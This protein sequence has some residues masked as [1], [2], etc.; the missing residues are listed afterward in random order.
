M[1][2]NHGLMFGSCV[3]QRVSLRND[4]PRQKGGAENSLKDGKKSKKRRDKLRSLEFFRLWLVI[5]LNLGNFSRHHITG[6]F[7]LY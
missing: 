2:G 1:E 4:T 7:N 6:V 5:T 3:V